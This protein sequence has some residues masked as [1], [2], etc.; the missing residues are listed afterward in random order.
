MLSRRSSLLLFT[1]AYFILCA[2]FPDTGNAE[3]S[4]ANPTEEELYGDFFVE[5][6]SALPA[7]EFVDPGV[8]DVASPS[9]VAPE[10]GAAAASATATWDFQ[11]DATFGLYSAPRRVVVD[12]ASL[13]ARRFAAIWLRSVK[14]D[15]TSLIEVRWQYFDA[16]TQAIGPAGGAL[17]VGYW[18]RANSGNHVTP[19]FANV[20]CNGLPPASLRFTNWLV[21]DT[22]TASIR[23]V[24]VQYCNGWRTAL[25]F[26]VGQGTMPAVAWQGFESGTGLVVWVSGS[27]LKGRFFDFSGN[28]LGSEFTI[29]SAAGV[30]PN[31]RSTDVIYNDVAGKFIV[32]YVVKE[33]LVY[34]GTYNRGV[35][36]DGTVDAL[37]NSAGACDSDV[38]GHET[39]VAYRSNPQ[40]Y[41]TWS[42][43]YGDTLGKAVYLHGSDGAR[44]AGHE[45]PAGTDGV[46][47]PVTDRK[48]Q[49]TPAAY[50]AALEFSSTV[51]SIK[52][53]DDATLSWSDL[54]SHTSRSTVEA[55]ESISPG[56][57]IVETLTP[58]FLP[59]GTD[60]FIK[61]FDQ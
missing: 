54:E 16:A 5:E 37:A 30:T 3:D 59:P 32:G 19:P 42:Y 18:V 9:A 45:I 29:D 22:D 61:V 26:T 12:L 41:Y 57:V 11:P 38:G 23:L 15:P 39:Y 25:S 46:L 10:G 47:A 48:M 40:G 21:H 60:W 27:N 56:T 31:F 2:P 14:Q 53:L 8:G 52:V 1:I 24:K 58:R 6:T 44:I 28:L 49:G 4:P 51:T 34:C 35:A 7:E 13:G 55:V 43:D 33:Q 20:Y 50:F 17:S 36:L